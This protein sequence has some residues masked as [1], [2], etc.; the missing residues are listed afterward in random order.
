MKEPTISFVDYLGL[1]PSCDL[2]VDQVRFINLQKQHLAGF[3]VPI[4]RSLANPF[5]TFLARFNRL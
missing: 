2:L 3:F 4:P 1:N 5:L